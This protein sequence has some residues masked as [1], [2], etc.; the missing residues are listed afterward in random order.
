M[1]HFDLF[2][3]CILLLPVSM[4]QEHADEFVKSCPT[5]LTDVMLLLLLV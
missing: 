1:D 2:Y 5:S 3:E 4:N